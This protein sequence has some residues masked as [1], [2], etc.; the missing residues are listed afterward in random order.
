M[1]DHGTTGT[2]HLDGSLCTG[3]AACPWSLTAWTA[4]NA[5]L[6]QQVSAAMALGYCGCCDRNVK[7][8]YHHDNHNPPYDG[9][10]YCQAC[11]D[12]GCGDPN[13]PCSWTD[14]RTPSPGGPMSHNPIT[15]LM[16]REDWIDKPDL[17]KSDKAVLDSLPIDQL[18]QALNEAMLSYE[19]VWH[20]MLDEV[21]S[22]ATES[23]LASVPTADSAP[24]DTQDECLNC[25]LP[26][27]RKG[28][29]W[30]DDIM[31]SSACMSNAETGV[32]NP[33]HVLAAYLKALQTGNAYR[34]DAATANKVKTFS[35]GGPLLYVLT[36]DGGDREDGNVYYCG[37]LLVN[38]PESKR[39]QVDAALASILGARVDGG[40]NVC[41]E[42]GKNAAA[43]DLF[44]DSE[45]LADELTKKGFAAMPIH[46]G[47]VVQAKP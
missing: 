24:E 5:A 33:R 43:D 1:A 2:H 35:P 15:P 28:G 13:D 17:S 7:T 12:A 8:P 38:E 11:Y 47:F 27:T 45:L 30:I 39:K 37:Y 6:S 42:R 4:A 16:L 9:Y 36:T 20:N 26:I 23:L 19:G 34:D 31:N 41:F 46:T 21:R 29:G 32:H 14:G 10:D 18:Q 44:E 22:R 25:A 3:T 40:G